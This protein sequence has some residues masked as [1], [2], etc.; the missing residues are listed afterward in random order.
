MVKL[1]DKAQISILDNADELKHFKSRFIIADPAVCYLDGNSLGRLPK[2]A[3]AEINK[4]LF[5]EWGKRV[6]EGWTDWIDEAEKVGDLVGAAALGAAAG[7]VLVMD[8]VSVNFY[9]LIR[10][11]ISLRPG[12]KVLVTDSANFP[13]NRYVL[14]GIAKELGLEIRLIDNEILPGRIGN[15][16]VTPEQLAQYLDDTVACVTLSQVNYRSGALHDVVALGEVARKQAIPFVWD[17]SHAVGVVNI[18]FDRDEVDFAVGC[19]YK[20]GNSGPGAPAWIYL[21]KRIQKNLN[22][23]IQGWFAQKNQFQMSQ[24]FEQ[25]DGMRGFQIASPSIIGLRCVK[26]SFEIIQEAT[27]ENISKKA[28]IGTHLMIELYDEWLAPLGFELVTPRE[29]KHRGGHISL[30]H[31]AAEK[32]ARGLREEM[33]LIPDYRVPNCLRVAIS[34]LYNTYSEIYEGFERIRDYTKSEKWRHLSNF[35]AKVT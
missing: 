26:A 33:K 4:F 13:T 20:Y 9:R 14:Q 24:E 12:K 8:T 2:N 6:V 27:I 25:A 30:S 23:P 17:A 3:I 19:T 18:Q 1:R 11:A 32:I 5:D 31:P 16:L 35:V 15:E 10:A 29:A 22:M 34:P 21:S 7:Q 28:A